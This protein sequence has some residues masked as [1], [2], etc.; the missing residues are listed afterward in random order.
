[1]KTLK[2]RDFLKMSAGTGAACVITPDFLKSSE[3]VQ[4]KNPAW[5]SPLAKGLVSPGGRSKVK[6]AKIYMGLP[7]PHWPKPSLD[8]QEE[9][10]IYENY[11]RQMPEEF[12]DVDF[13]VN[14]L[15][16]KPED[17]LRHAD[18][19]K[20]ADGILAI[21]LTIWISDILNAIL[22]FQRPTVIFAAPYSGHEWT[23]YGRLM[24]EER[25][26]LVDCFLSSN[27]RDLARAVRPFRAIHHLKEA[28]ILNLTTAPFEE[29]A[30]KVKEK[31]GVEIKRITL[32]RV[33]KTYAAISEAEARREAE[34]WYEGAERVVE[35]TKEEVYRSARLALAF[36]K[37]V[38]EEQATALTIDCYGTMWDKTIK[39]PA[40][41][42]LGFSRLNSRGLGGICESDLRSAL[43]HIIFQGLTGKPGFISDPTVDEARDYIILAHCMGTVNMDG[44]GKPGHPYKLRT[45]ME[46]EE[47]VVPQ[48]RMRKGEKVTQ[49]IL[50]GTE[51]LLYFTGE[52]V[53]TPVGLEDDRGC[54]TKIAVRV[55]G[56]L[57]KLWRNWS[58]GLHRVTCY[59]ELSRELR[60]LARFKKLELI[61]EA[62]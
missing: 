12:S 8:P 10:K 54:R 29:Y 57:D 24:K 4:I 56:S 36:E 22:N 7:K 60:M 23:R 17:V 30:E 9:M 16:S 32:D 43:T 62:I 14:I 45:V 31:F 19:I 3:N 38:E 59:G 55:D 41:P 42:C 39:L 37:L 27:S 5:V 49:A 52:I 20:E 15:A 51:K 47:G 28:K 34:L 25:G 18:K 44:P 33:E 21:H 61:N 6:V 2:R 53:D 50:V 40:Y 46:R 26:A 1:M 13:V 48:V 58:Y 11:F 35:P